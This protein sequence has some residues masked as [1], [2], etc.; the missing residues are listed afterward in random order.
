MFCTEAHMCV[1]DSY[2]SISICISY[3]FVYS[4]TYFY[5]CRGSFIRVTGLMYFRLLHHVTF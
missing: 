3:T 5:G 2:D 4:M 1:Y